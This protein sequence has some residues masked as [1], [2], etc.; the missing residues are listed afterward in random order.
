MKLKRSQQFKFLIKGNRTLNQA[1]LSYIL[2]REEISTCITG[3]KSV[4]QLRSNVAATQVKL[5][6]AEFK[7]IEEIQQN[8][9]EGISVTG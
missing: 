8:W 5:S 9:N 3:S 2:C 1:A 7:K 4:E 6:T